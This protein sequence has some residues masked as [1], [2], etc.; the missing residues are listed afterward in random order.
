MSAACLINHY[1]YGAY[2]G[3]AIASVARQTRPLDEILVV[4][5]GS[6][7]DELEELR[8]HVAGHPAV[9]LHE[10]PNEGQLSCFQ[11]GLD[12]TEADVLFFL[13]ADDRWQPG[14]VER[15][16]RLLDERPDVDFVATAE[17]RVFPDGRTTEN[18][19]PSR[20]L[21]YSVVRGLDRGGRWVGQPTSCLAIRRRIVEKILPLPRAENW[22]TC[23]DEALVYG[24]SVVGARKYFL[25]E[26]L[27]DYRMHGQNAFAGRSYEACDRLQRGIEVV[28]LVETLRKRFDLPSDLAH[29]AHHEFRTIPEP[30]RDEYRD[31]C[32]IVN[33]AGL[34]PD[35]RRRRRLALWRWFYMRK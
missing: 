7:P 2:V 17:R 5:D 10:K 11:V 1:N 31:Y 23:A 3:E 19:A 22:R 35:R 27:V 20:D 24:A 8:A 16:M 13:D 34:P 6:S 26:P 30:V 15:V 9:Q 18:E 33:N 29:L 12:R 32:R 21:G 4:D 14:Y 25:G 28:R